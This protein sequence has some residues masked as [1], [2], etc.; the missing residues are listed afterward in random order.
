MERKK[1]KMIFKMVILI[2]GALVIV[3]G[4]FG[5][6]IYQ[7]SQVTTGEK[8]STDLS[9]KSALLVLDVQNDTLGI[10]EYGNT[11]SLMEN[12]NSA[13][14]YAQNNNIDIVY[15]K[16]EFSNPIDKLMSGQLYE[17]NTNGSELSSL[18]DV[19]SSNIFSKEKTDAF[20]NSELEE[21]LLKEKITTLYIVGADA[22]ACIFKTSLGGKVRGYEVIILEDSIFSIND[23]LL[24]S[25]IENYAKKDI[26][27]CT[28]SDFMKQKTN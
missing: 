17:K 9:S 16:Q 19:S 23:K 26:K 10:K 4:I 25:S 7:L 8:I 24:N 13:V 28:L 6:R 21:Y 3:G 27:T 1:K 12:I 22:S 14:R 20:S 18:L 15:T 11:D 5:V 2:I